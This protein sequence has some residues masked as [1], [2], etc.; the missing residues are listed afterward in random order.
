MASI[1]G[2][3]LAGLGLFF[4]GIKLTSENL[5][6]L[7]SRRFRTL[8][9]RSLHTDRLAALWGAAVGAV[10]QSGSGV[11]YIVVGLLSSGSV[12][13]RRALP[14]V[15]WSNVGGAALVMIATLDLDLLKYYLL[16]LAGLAYGFGR[17]RRFRYAVG[18]IFGVALILFGLY[19]MASQ[20]VILQ[21]QP[22]FQH[23]LEGTGESYLLA[24]LSGVLLTTLAQSSAAVSL[25]AIQMAG[26]GVLTVEQAILV[27]YGSNLG[28]SANFG[29]VLANRFLSVR[30]AGAPRQVTA[31]QVLFDLVGCAIFVPLFMLETMGHL[32]LML[33][34]VDPSAENLEL[35]LAVVFLV[36]NAL[37]AALLSPFSDRLAAWL[38]RT[39][40][41]TEQEDDSRVQFVGEASPEAP[42]AALVLVAR[43]Q[44][45]L[46]RRL[47]RYLELVGQSP[48]EVEAAQAAFAS[49]AGQ[50]EEL[51]G[52]LTDTDLTRGASSR[53]LN[54]HNRHS[55]IV[56]LED[57]L[58]RLAAAMT[59]GHTSPTLRTRTDN[60][61]QALD[62]LLLTTLDTVASADPIDRELL[63]EITSDRGDVM[64]RLRQSFLAGESQLEVA[65]RSALFYLTTLL[66]RAIWLIHE[67]ARLLDEP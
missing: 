49:V 19:M 46:L 36:Y 10:I 61:I 55:L 29:A 52:S 65:D 9:S 53:L 60:F 67:L 66:E 58:A 45:R 24:F 18:A 62:A 8:L 42:E 59:T 7:T 5:R 41:A 2:V 35:R 44:E 38:E 63:L 26:S 33:P 21:D 25:V 34:L 31:Y 47:P 56:S 40:P 17:P 32:T 11:G 13:L 57:S 20:A 23:A 54:L 22:W 43:E 6:K 14:L 3:M 64:E 50:I 1:L 51:L 37:T 4:T 12:T 48:V 15:C 16:G 39:W 28:G 30:Q 27:M